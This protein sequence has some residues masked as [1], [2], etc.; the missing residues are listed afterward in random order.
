MDKIWRV[1][2]SETDC[3]PELLAYIVDVETKGSSAAPSDHPNGPT[4]GALQ[5]DDYPFEYL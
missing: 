2:P 4:P 3:E 1:H 5:G